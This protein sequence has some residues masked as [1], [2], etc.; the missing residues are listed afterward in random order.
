MLNPSSSYAHPGKTAADGCHYC[1]TNC[2]KWGV[3]WNQRH[4][5]TGS[6]NNSSTN[7]YPTSTPNQNK[8]YPTFTPKPKPTSIIK[9]TITYKPIAT[10]RIP[11]NTI[12]PKIESKSNITETPIVIRPVKNKR[13]L[14]E[15]I[16][17]IL[18]SLSL[19]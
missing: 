9:P 16:R 17:K 11:I 2:D 1:R 15:I 6:T 7:V 12:S 19:Y 14:L 18:S 5:H 4:C 13:G 3:P 8:I 10:I